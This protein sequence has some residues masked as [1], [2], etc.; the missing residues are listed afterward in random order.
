LEDLQNWS[1]FNTKLEEAIVDAAGSGPPQLLVKFED[2]WLSPLGAG[3]G[4]GEDSGVSA[5]TPFHGA[6]MHRQATI[7]AGADYMRFE[8]FHDTQGDSDLLQIAFGNKLLYEQP[9][10]GIRKPIIDSP[11]IYVGDLAGTTDR[12]LI[13]LTGAGEIGTSVYLRNLQFYSLDDAIGLP[14][15]FNFSGT[16]DAADYVVWR[17]GLGTTYT[18]ADYNLWRANF[19]EESSGNAAVA[20]IPE[21]SALLLLVSCGL[22]MLGRRR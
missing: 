9:I 18:Q 7:P 8:I 22:I 14:G 15:D 17:N 4:V 12:F 5:G 16:V 11:A 20:T 19:G 1:G 6:Q 3:S 21:P 13:S 10:F 2:L